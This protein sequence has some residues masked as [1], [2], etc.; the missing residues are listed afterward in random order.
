ML[1]VHKIELKPNRK[2]Q[3][4]F[5]RS[6]GVARFA[7][8]WALDQWQKW[9]EAGDKPTEVKL[10]KHL[11]QIKA[12][13][14]PW[15]LAVTKVAPQQAIKNLGSA[16]KR[17]FEK[18]GQ[19]PQFKKRGIHDS[20]RADNGP[21]KA[22]DSAVP[23]EGKRIRLPK[24]GWVRLKEA[25][26][27]EG[28]IKSVVISKRA[29]RWYAA[30]SVETD[31]LPH[32]RKNQGLV[33]VDLGVKHLAVLSNG[34]CIEGPK[35][36]AKALARLKRLSR[37]LSR[38]K[39]GSANRCKAKIRLAKLHAKVRHIRENALHQLSTHLVLNY[40]QIAIEDLNV[41]GMMCNKRLAKSIMDQGFYEFRRQLT[42][43]AKWYDCEIVLADRF[44]PSSKRCHL[45]HHINDALTLSERSW[46]CD[47]GAN[48]DRDIN[49]AKNLESLIYTHPT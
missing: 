34:Q 6:C 14:F 45:C 13:D 22:G 32:E 41:K 21:A 24:I 42:Y 39:K 40:T 5:Q 26:R 49:A 11:N 33:G 23:V 3:T 15:M 25:L 27:F 38:K 29:D 43:K 19:Y 30:I 35:A 37:G 47:C 44:F 7:Y 31:Q 1:L 16:F 8:N 48:H 4:Y 28:Q 36:Y 10:R 46:Q 2:Q 17:F 9:Y 18:Q 20:F 12:V